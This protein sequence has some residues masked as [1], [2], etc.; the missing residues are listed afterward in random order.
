MG[1]NNLTIVILSYNTKKITGKCLT[2]V[3]KASIYCEKILKNKTETIAV[4][5][6][7]TDGSV[8]MIHKKFPWLKLVDVG[9]NL[10]FAGGNNLGMAKAKSPFI[11]LLNSDA[12]L[13]KDTLYKAL[14]YM[15]AHIECD[16]LCVR[17]K[18]PDGSFQPSGGFL[19]TPAKTFLWMMGLDNIPV[20]RRF[21]RPIHVWEKSFYKREKSF[22]WASG[23]FFLL[24]SSV[25]KK[26][27]GFDEN[28]FLYSEDIEWC[29]RLKEG[30]FK[31]CY[32]PDI[33][34]V[35]VAGASSRLKEDKSLISQMKGFIYYHKKYYPKY[36]R[37][38]KS[39]MG[40]GFWLRI[41][42]YTIICQRP[43]VKAY[44]E[45]LVVIR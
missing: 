27:K 35:H 3:R 21:M 4:D 1:G 38:T 14:N 12:F 42:L 25:Y 43:A 16:C 22:E 18:F 9:K 39:V 23:A 32:T 11:L 6:G 10:G 41:I 34:V 24:R 44:K 30:D 13:E 2:C 5:N 37:F 33:E 31:I 29:K 26:T 7:S 20:V 36:L 40:I 17:L 45:A 28:L 19:P 15:D 8:E